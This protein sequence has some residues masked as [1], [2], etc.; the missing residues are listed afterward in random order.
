MGRVGEG[1]GSQGRLCIVELP[2]AAG[3]RKEM[4]L[5]TGGG[6]QLSQDGQ[7]LRSNQTLGAEGMRRKG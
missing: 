7:R 3:S 4:V 5:G 1:N 2:L 6:G